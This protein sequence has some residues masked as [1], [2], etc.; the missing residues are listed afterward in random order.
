MTFTHVKSHEPP[1]ISDASTRQ[2]A[3]SRE[4][5]RPTTCALMY[6][7]SSLLNRTLTVPTRVFSS[8]SASFVSRIFVSVYYN[9]Y[10]QRN[11]SPTRLCQAFWLL[12]VLSWFREQR[13]SR[14]ANATP[15]RVVARGRRARARLT[16]R[17]RTSC[18]LSASN[19]SYVLIAGSCKHYR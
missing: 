2:F 19:L 5:L 16:R 13:H 12:N 6:T 7:V 3:F 18:A 1:A 9:H 15:K 10:G 4:I 11:Y 17:Q 14:S 8:S